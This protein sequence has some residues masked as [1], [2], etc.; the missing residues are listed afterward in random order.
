VTEILS[1]K[2]VT[3]SFDGFTVIDHLSLSIEKGELRFLIG[4]NGAGKTTLLDLLSGKTRPV[5]GQI[6]YD[7][8][9]DV[10]KEAEH[11]LVR[12][13]IGRK[14]QTPAIFR[15]LTCWQHLEVAMGF[16]HALP[17]L[18]K[19]ISSRERERIEDA[20]ETVGLAHRAG[21]RA[22]ALSHGEQQWLEISMLLVQEAQLLLLDEPVAG[23]TRQERE[24][25]GEL[26]HSLEG[27]H[28]VII[29]E[30]D[31]DFVR[32]FSRTVT[33]LHQ[34]KII[35][36]GPIEQVQSDPLVVE[37]YLGRSLADAVT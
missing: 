21:V 36:N 2:D 12:L 28:T 9:V 35:S 7:E 32:R 23:M 11:E 14:F 24:K 8:K 31:M 17:S 3:V 4:P 33:V 1:L 37:V 19:G 27:K 29:T 10:G 26:I 6:I 25:T 34:G 30:H 20:L 18:F 13:G 5:S 16:R 15:N 22:G